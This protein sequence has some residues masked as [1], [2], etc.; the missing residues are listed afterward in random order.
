MMRARLALRNTLPSSPFKSGLGGDVHIRAHAGLG[1]CP[2]ND[3][4]GSAKSIDGG[5]V[6]DI[7]AMLQRG[8]DGGN[9]FS[10]IGSAPHPPA[11]GPGA[12]RDG[13]DLE[14]CAGNIGKLH[15]HFESFGLT[16]HDPAP[17]SCA[18]G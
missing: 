4:L 14:R 17:S 3:L 7:D 9:R 13:R 15:V 12:E 18:C 10:F 16:S 2:A 5:R 11:N 1:D 6:D 8:T